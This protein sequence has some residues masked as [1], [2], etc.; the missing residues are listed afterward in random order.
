MLRHWILLGAVL[1]GFFFVFVP[2][3]LWVLDKMFSKVLEQRL[4]AVRWNLS[5]VIAAIILWVYWCL[6]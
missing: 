5:G 2:G 4:F 3:I 1:T 6:I